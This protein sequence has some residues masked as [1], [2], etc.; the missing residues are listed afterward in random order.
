MTGEHRGVFS[1][2][3]DDRN[4]MGTKPCQV[5][6]RKRAHAMK[7]GAKHRVRAD[8]AWQLR[9]TKSEIFLLVLSDTESQAERNKNGNVCL[10]QNLVWQQAMTLVD[11]RLW[12]QIYFAI[13]TLSNIAKSLPEKSSLTYENISEIGCLSAV[14]FPSNL[15]RMKSNVAEFERTK[16]HVVQLGSQRRTEFSQVISFH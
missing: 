7:D 12:A 4:I 16:N 13:R 15:H 6:S 14:L 5:I 8:S 2:I 1:L 9:C 3:M 11:S 10:K